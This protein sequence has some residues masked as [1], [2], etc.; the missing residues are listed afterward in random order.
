[1]HQGTERATDIEFREPAQ[2]AQIHH[3]APERWNH[4]ENNS[5]LACGLMLTVQP[6]SAWM[7][8]DGA[9]FLVT[10][11]GVFKR[12]GDDSLDLSVTCTWI[13][14]C[15]PNF[16]RRCSFNL[17][18]HCG[19]P[20][21]RYHLSELEQTGTLLVMF[22]LLRRIT[23]DVLFAHFLTNCAFFVFRSGADGVS[24]RCGVWSQF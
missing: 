17:F 3:S 5:L 11:D 16:T 2:R 23:L 24:G 19:L 22:T 21:A 8:F 14:C 7:Q 1:M 13:S 6:P 10:T 15:P 9:V 18:D 12:T 4:A 20:S